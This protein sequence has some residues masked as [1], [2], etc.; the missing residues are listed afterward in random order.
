MKIKY[1]ISLLILIAVLVL[2]YFLDKIFP[3]KDILSSMKSDSLFWRLSFFLILI[4]SAIADSINPCEFAVMFILLNSVM[5]WQQ[6]NKK[7][8]AVWIAFILA[9]FL[10]YFL[11]W[12]GLYNA[13]TYIP[14]WTD[15]VKLIAWILWVLVWLASL[16][17]YFWYWKLF[18]FEVPDS[19]RPKMKK[20]IRKITSPTWGFLIWILIS[21]FLLPCTSG[22]YITILWYLSSESSSLSTWWYIYLFIYNIIFILPMIAILMIVLLWARDVWELQEMK[23]I[24]V[25]KLHLI[26][27]IVMLLLS[28]YIF[29]DLYNT[30]AFERIF[31]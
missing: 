6:S 30:W 24:H 11:M 3:V 2:F 29:Y 17:D 16:K 19:W 7:V 8:I 27:W 14:W 12:L 13:L 20:L 9:V 5:K 26:T 21:L 15:V 1:I 23:E 22:P 28:A 4:P 31:W 10:S 18:K 25:E